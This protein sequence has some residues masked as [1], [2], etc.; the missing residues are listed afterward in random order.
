MGNERVFNSLGAQWINPA[1]GGSAGV[2][3]PLLCV[4]PET[5]FGEM[6]K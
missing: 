1:Q 3:T 2:F 5:T 6:E 4:S